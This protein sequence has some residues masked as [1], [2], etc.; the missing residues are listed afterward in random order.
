MS[1]RA[2]RGTLS[3]NPTPDVGNAEKGI[4][5]NPLSAIPLAEIHRQTLLAEADEAR[6]ARQLPRTGR[7]GIRE[8]MR[9]VTVDVA[10]RA[11]VLRPAGH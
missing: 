9:R 6:L 2:P 4:Q 11:H 5:M 7:G 10:I 3:S 8:A 1:R